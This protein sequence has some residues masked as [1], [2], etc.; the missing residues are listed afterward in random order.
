VQHEILE[1]DRASV[2]ADG[3]VLT[4]QVNCAAEAGDVRD[5]VPY[6]L[7]VSL[8]AAPHLDVPVF[9]EISQRIRPLVVVRA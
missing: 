6:A 5:E 7:A 4:I 1:G 2:F 9:A 3:D 8:E